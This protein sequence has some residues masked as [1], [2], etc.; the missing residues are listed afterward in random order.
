MLGD[1]PANKTTGDLQSTTD[2]LEDESVVQTAAAIDS[3][4]FYFSNTLLLAD[5]ELTNKPNQQL[6]PNQY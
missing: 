1:R 2:M 3:G 4:K 6:S 5:Y